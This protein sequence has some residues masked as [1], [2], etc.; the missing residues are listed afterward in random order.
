MHRQGRQEL[1]HTQTAAHTCVQVCM[2]CSVCYHQAFPLLANVQRNV[3]F[4]IVSVV[5]LISLTVSVC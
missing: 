1:Q 2:S 3:R 5:Y 4:S